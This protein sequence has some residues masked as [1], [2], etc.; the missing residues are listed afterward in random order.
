MSSAQRTLLVT[1]AAAGIGAEIARAAAADGYRV[2]VLDTDGPGAGGCAAGIPGA[3]ALEASVTDEAAVEA[4]LD[5]FGTPDV[6]V[7]NAGIVRFGPLLEQAADSFRSVVDVN[8]VGTF[9]CGRATARRMAGAGGGRIVNVASMNGIVPGPNAGAYAA[10]KAGIM[11]LT[12]QMA[13]E[14]SRHGIRVNC[15]APGLIDGGMSAPI[16]ADPQLRA[17]R[18]L[19]IPRGRLGTTADIARAVLWLASD[20]ADY[21][22]GQTLLVDGGVTMSILSHLPRP[23]S[24]DGVGEA[25]RTPGRAADR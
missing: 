23:R 24:V 15:V 18:E 14:W 11:M 21:V 12:Q 13:L 16:H 17:E 4:A 2:G 20:G 7:N 5:A 19:A 9:L 6:L 25:T 8:L 22:T 3:V 1:G 10:T